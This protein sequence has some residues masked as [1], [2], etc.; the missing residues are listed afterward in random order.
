MADPI[1]HLPR[2]IYD[3]FWEHLF[4]LVIQAFC[5][6]TELKQLFCT[7]LFVIQACAS[8]GGKATFSIKP[9]Y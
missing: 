2:F 3:V 9:R 1:R 7:T 8:A 5:L 6:F 4:S